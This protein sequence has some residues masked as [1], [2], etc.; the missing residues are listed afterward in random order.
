MSEYIKELLRLNSIKYE[1]FK[2]CERSTEIKMNKLRQ[3]L[4][5]SQRLPD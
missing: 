2:R 4:K 3:E 5:R 1:L